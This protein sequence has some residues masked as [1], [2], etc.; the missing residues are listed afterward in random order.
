MLFSFGRYFQSLTPIFKRTALQRTLIV[1]G[2]AVAMLTAIQSN[3]VLADTATPVPTVTATLNPDSFDFSKATLFKADGDI[4]EI[5]VPSGWQTMPSTGQ[6][7]EKIFDFTYGDSG[8]IV[9]L[10]L[11]IADATYL[12][13]AIDPTGKANSPEIALQSIITANSTPPAAGSSPIKFSPVVDVK[14]GSLPGKGFIADVPASAQS[15]EIQFDLRI[16]PAANGKVL[17][18]SARSNA[19]LW[20]KAQIVINQMLDSVVV[21]INNIPTATPT[22]TL[23]PLYITATALQGQINAMQGSLT[24][25]ATATPSA[26]LT[27]T[28]SVTPTAPPTATF[29]P[30]GLDF[31]SAKL[32]KADN[33]IFEIQLPSNWKTDLVSNTP[34]LFLSSLYYGSNSA[35]NSPVALSVSIGTPEKVLSVPNMKPDLTTD[36]QLQALVNLAATPQP[37][38]P[39][40]TIG[41]VK[42]AQ[43]GKLAAFAVTIDLA[44]DAKTPQ[45]VKAQ[46]LL[47]SLPNG[48]VVQVIIQSF[49]DKY[50]AAWPVMNKMIDSLIIKE[51]NMDL[52]TT[53]T[54]AATSTLADVAVTT[55]PDGLQYV[56]T[57]IGSGTAAVNG[58][59]LTVN[60][61]GKLADGTQF[62]TS[63][64]KT[65]FSFTLGAGQVIK[66]WDE[67]LVGMKVGGKRTLTIPPALGYGAAGQG[68][69]PAN[70]TLIFEVELLSVK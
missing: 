34:D 19:D 4:L 13:S 21:N 51:K 1:G 66:G 14:V 63:I 59:T 22:A 50:D 55:L 47:A 31:N 26:T 64:G 46:I 2:L 45:A 20:P 39:V 33:D 62:D 36:G 29:D 11:Q 7:G 67:G 49:A 25:L 23:H 27:P 17:Y 54:P 16:A 32:Y 18:V 37:G 5:E 44:A 68:P 38:S 8:P 69:I 43:L 48:K 30:A 40:Y 9:S 10:Q 12:Y 3:R 28:A 15:A 6:N 56:D 60:Y 53:P 42:S 58:Q 35:T 57:V 24:P 65:P 52:P 61:T 70:S 41:K